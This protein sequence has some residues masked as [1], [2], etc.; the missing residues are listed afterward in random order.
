MKTYKIVSTHDV[1]VDSFSEG[2]QEYV[3]HYNFSAEIKKDNVNEAI[4]DYIKNSLYFNYHK[5]LTYKENN[6]IYLSVL[7]DEDNIEANEKQIEQW[8]NNKLTLYVNYVEIEVYELVRV[9]L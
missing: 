5:K 7:V 4:E 2:E 9:E 1:Y 8:K 6:K 3:N